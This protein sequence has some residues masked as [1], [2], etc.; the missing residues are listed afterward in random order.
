MDASSIIKSIEGVTK[1]WTKQ[2]KQEERGRAQSRRDAMTSRR[3]RVGR[4]ELTTPR[5][6]PSRS[7]RLEP[8][9]KT[10]KETSASRQ[11]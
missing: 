6:P 4:T 5:K 1:K 11:N 3:G 8:R 2:R 9:P 10:R 7:R